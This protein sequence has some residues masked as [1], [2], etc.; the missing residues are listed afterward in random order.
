VI[1]VAAISVMTSSI[2]AAADSTAPVQL[3][4]PTVR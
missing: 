1:L 4:S 2:V 3:M